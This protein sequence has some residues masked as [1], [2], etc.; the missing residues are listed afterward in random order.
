[1][2][3]ALRFS[4][5]HYLAL[6]LAAFIAIVWANTYAV[7]Y[8]QI[9]Q[10]LAFVVNDLGMAFALAYVAQEVVE[11]VLPGGSL[12][13]WQSAVTPM[14]A[15]AGGLLGAAAVYVGYIRSG[16]EQILAPGWPVACAVDMLVCVGLGRAIFGRSVAASFLVLLVVASNVGGLAVISRHHL[17]AEVHPAAALLIVL[18][19]GASAVLRRWGV[20]SVWPYLTLSGPP[21]WLGCY[22]TGLHPA[23]SLLP[24]VP[25]FTHSPRY[26]NLDRAVPERGTHRTA[27]HFEYLFK[28]PVQVIAFLF[29]LVNVGARLQGFGT[30]T[31]AVLTASLAGRPLGILAAVGIAVAARQSLPPQIGW[32][33]VVV[34]AL[35][36][37]PGLAFG[38]FFAT[39]VFPDGPLLIETKLGAISTVVGVIVALA[40]AR[41]LHVGRFAK[42]VSPGERLHA[43]LTEGHA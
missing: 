26:L 15:A 28:Y 34:I 20:R 36:A 7:S 10:S 14:I 5:E 6:P 1:M 27:R 33:D 41:L 30:G 18:A 39:T 13:P 38:V 2:T 22:W 40:A 37:S 12:Y 24:I 32:R 23:L 19:I 3:R 43:P 16:D 17:V 8:F 35:A 11:A 9:A 25:F 31:W 4:I 21:M 42:L 29:G